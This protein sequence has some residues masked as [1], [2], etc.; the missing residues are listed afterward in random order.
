VSVQNSDPQISRTY[1]NTLL[2]TGLAQA[3]S[4]R[5]VIVLLPIPPMPQIV[6]RRRGKKAVPDDFD[7]EA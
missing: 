2:W 1:S 5:A 3:L 6:K 7:N 4:I